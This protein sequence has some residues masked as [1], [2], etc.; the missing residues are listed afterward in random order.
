MQIKHNL[1]FRLFR[2]GKDNNK[3]QIRARITFNGERI[4]VSS[5]IILDSQKK[6]DP[7]YERVIGDDALS[8]NAYLLKLR[9]NVELVMK[10]FEIQEYYPSAIEFKGR[11]SLL[12]KGFS[13][14]ERI[15]ARQKDSAPKF[16]E[17]FDKFMLECGEKNAWTTA[18]CQKWNALR[19]DLFNYKPNI[20]FDDLN[21]NVLT[22]FVIYLRDIKPLKTPRKPRGQR[23]DY[24]PDDVT[25]I[26]NST[27]EKKLEY[28]RWFLN[29]ATTNGYNNNLAY[30]SF[31]PTLKKTQKKVIYLSKEELARI[32]SLDLTNENE[33]LDPV[34][35]VFLFCCFSGL[36][37]SDANNLYRS[38]IKD[39]HIEITTV[40]TADSLKIE[41]ND[42]TQTILDKYKDV[43][44]KDNKVLPSL[45]NQAMNRDLKVLCKLAGICEEIRVTTYKGSE[46]RDEICQKWELIGTHTGRR[47]FIVNALSL[48]I[49]P[50]IVMKWTGH[51]D[52]KAMKPYID[53]VD[54]IKADSMAKFNGLI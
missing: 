32:Q 16:Y 30:K 42:V 28:L 45:T 8:F 43:P 24:D 27:L 7:T 3:Y 40:K 52:Y 5:G 15:V 41:L 6:W 47:T 31:R 17:V 2:Y 18:T 38:D 11:L 33:Y 22:G 35:D 25:G 53:I 51:S 14:E 54:T 23:L 13:K 10:E 4:D 48:G 29:W 19:R 26:K 12:L 39:G 9:D 49:A 20:T 21:E 37:H 50:S 44:F 46:R 36:R 34:R 1:H